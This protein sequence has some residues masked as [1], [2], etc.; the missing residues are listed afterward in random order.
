VKDLLKSRW[1]LS[2]IGLILV[3]LVIWF[4]GP[5]LGLGSFRP[6]QSVVGRL[7]AILV[8]VVGWAL[9]LQFRIWKSGRAA[10]KLAQDVAEEPSAPAS[11]SLAAGSARDSAQLRARFAEAT[12]ALRKDRKGGGNLYDLPWYVIIG[13][14]GAGK[15]TALANSGLRFPLSKQFGKEALRGVGGTRNCDWWFTSEGVFLD[16]AGRFTTQDSDKAEDSAAWGEFLALLRKHRRRQPINGVLVAVSVPDLI[17]ASDREIEAMSESVRERLDELNK[18]LRINLPV[19]LL[20]T[21]ADLIAGFAEFFDDLGNDGRSQVWGVT[22]PLEASEAGNA[23]E[24]FAGEFDELVG[25]LNERLISRLDEERDPRRRA[26]LFTFPQQAASVKPVLDRFLGSVFSPTRY[27]S[28]AMLRGVYFTSGT[29]E[30]TPIDRMLA[31]LTRGSGIE[32]Q[33]VAARGGDGRAY[34]IAQLLRDVVLKESG[35]AGTSRRAEFQRGALQVGAYSLAIALG[36]AGAIALFTS[37]RTNSAY[38]QEVQAATQALEATPR[39]NGPYTA[40]TIEALLPRLDGLRTVVDTATQHDGDVPWRMRWG[41]YQGDSVGHSAT[42]AYTREL[43]ATLAPAITDAFRQRLAA[44]STDPNRLYEYLKAYL[45]L[46]DVAHRDAGQLAFLSRIEWEQR[47]PDRPD[48]RQQLGKHLQFLLD[49]RDRLAPATLDQ[50]LVSQARAALLQASLPALVYSR[51][52]LNYA[53]DTERALRL[54]IESGL[55]A[56]SV[57]TRRSGA[58][59]SEPV[60]AIYTRPVFEE[61]TGQGAAGLAKQFTEDS[62]VLGDDGPSVIGSAQLIFDVFNVYEEDYIRAWDA[63]LADVTVV[64]VAG[65]EQAALVLGTVGSATSPLRGF[66][67]TVSANTDLLADEANAGDA[68]PASAAADAA[69]AQLGKVFESGAAALG[70]TP[71][72]RPGS[73]VTAH[74]APIH[75]L[76]AGPVGGA[77]ID[78][79]LQLFGQMQ[80]QLNT[81]QAGAGGGSPAQ[82]LAQGGG[83]ALVQQLQVETK[84]LPPAVG[85]IVAEIG[86]ESQKLAQGQV[87][88]ELGNLYQ[89]LVALPC[90]EVV[91]GRYPFQRAAKVDV[92]LADF[93]R[94]FG[95]G[96]VFDSFFGQHLAPLADTS[97][98]P[99]RWRPT[100]KGVGLPGQVL[101]QFEQVARIRDVYFASGGA[102]PGFDFNLTPEFLDASA[103]R[104]AIEVDGQTVDYRHGPQQSTTMKWP[105]SGAGQ[106][107]VTLELQGGASPN[108]VFNGPWAFFRLLDSASV[109]PQTDTRFQVSFA[110]GGSSARVLIDAASIRNPLR[111]NVLQGFSCG[112]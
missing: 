48:L 37:Y 82:V 26:A 15:T 12:A 62:W 74:F 34:F 55:G 43:N 75:R 14:P 27:D 81:V 21:K 20:V 57:L 99:W 90:A 13:P 101:T 109:Q 86:G 45:M 1:L 88:T 46:G 42:D 7:I 51:L 91:N 25:R 84:M 67:A 59:M 80:Q 102:L 4:G 17:T 65:V 54:D 110:I 5:Y 35:L 38:V 11:R 52:K 47:Y 83:A 56:D 10:G 29:Q 39:A 106:A 61:I 108:S 36:I 87:R 66:L 18:H 100:A 19:Y 68:D 70:V 24:L 89:Q 95:A 30:G 49:D 3:A 85:A 22:F 97:R 63:I 32:Q 105:G 8:L 72:E 78:R 31:V 58:P 98:S 33:A 50:G 77:P 6:L 71:T 79:V 111:E 76:M 104:M 40:D 53:G 112:A 94:I 41:L 2:A 16:T 69:Q 60:P 44:Y 96:G 9:Y 73:R 64:P 103:T 28:G 107:A 93:G 92:P 23:A